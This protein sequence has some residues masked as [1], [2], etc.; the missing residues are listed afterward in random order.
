MEYTLSQNYPNSFNP[1]TRIK[2]SI[3]KASYVEIIVFNSLGEE[4]ATIVKE[5]KDAGNYEAS[6]NAQELSSGI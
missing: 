3:S 2:Y 1:F 5:Y 4:I 6:F